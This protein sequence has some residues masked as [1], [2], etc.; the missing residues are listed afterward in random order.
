MLELISTSDSM[1]RSAVQAI[2]RRGRVL[3][4]HVVRVNEPFRMDGYEFYQNQFLRPDQGGP[5]S[6]F[7]VKYDPFVPWIYVGFALVAA[8]VITMLWFPGQRAFKLHAHLAAL[9]QEKSE[10]SSR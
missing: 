5:L 9:P 6:V 2:D 10:G 3:A 1:Y 8:G 4:E 7:R